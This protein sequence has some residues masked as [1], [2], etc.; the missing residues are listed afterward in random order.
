MWG[1]KRS[2]ILEL[3]KMSNIHG[4]ILFHYICV[5]AMF[6][7]L[8]SLF[9]TWKRRVD[10]TCGLLVTYSPKHGRELTGYFW[11]MCQVPRWPTPS[12]ITEAEA[13][14]ICLDAVSASQSVRTCSADVSAAL[15]ITQDVTSCVSDIQVGAGW[16][17]AVI[18]LPTANKDIYGCEQFGLIW[19]VQGVRKWNCTRAS[20]M[21][22]HLSAEVFLDTQ[23][24][25]GH[26]I[27]WL[28]KRGSQKSTMKGQDEMIRIWQTLQLFQRQRCRNF[29]DVWNLN[30]L[31]Q[32]LTCILNWTEGTFT[33]TVDMLW[34]TLRALLLCELQNCWCVYMVP[35]ICT[36]HQ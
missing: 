20:H 6:L 34:C 27:N 1:N 11:Y 5:Q 9:L 28:E 13:R 16:K 30:W 17:E 12:G 4:L 21:F 36:L 2:L 32:M 18:L 19:L 25:G 3:C 23:S 31:P 29:W 22:E 8:T 7:L 35:N 24:Q 15:S 26:T 33:F 14:K 10:S